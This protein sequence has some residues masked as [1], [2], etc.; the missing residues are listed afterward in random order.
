MAGRTACSVRLHRAVVTLA[1]GMF[2]GFFRPACLYCWTAPDPSL[3][4]RSGGKFGGTV[5]YIL[6]GANVGFVPATLFL[7]FDSH[8]AMLVVPS[9]HRPR[10]WSEVT[11]LLEEGLLAQKEVEQM[12]EGLP[13]AANRVTAAGV[14]GA[15]KGTLIDLQGFLEFDRQVHV[16]VLFVA[17]FC[18]EGVPKHLFLF[19]LFTCSLSP[20]YFRM[21]IF[22]GE[23]GGLFL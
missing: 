1:T 6:I 11:E 2:V 22:G 8:F 10:R 16:S 21:S 12:W 3:H 15:D 14:P 23:R 7:G 13:K 5:S 20:K 18:G 4:C 19:Y 9:P 17:E